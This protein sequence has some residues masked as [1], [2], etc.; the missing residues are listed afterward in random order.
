[1]KV[2]KQEAWDKLPFPDWRA[3]FFLE[4]FSESLSVE[5]P[6]FHQA[7]MMG[8][9]DLA[10]EVLENIKVYEENDKG[11]G[12]LTSSLKELK[13][14][15]ERDVV[16]KS[17]F[18]DILDVFDDCAKN[19]SADK[20]SRSLIIQLS[21][22]CKRIIEQ[23]DLYFDTIK[24]LLIESICDNRDISEKGRI[25]EEIYS[26]TRAY[27]TFLLSSGYSPTYL[28]NKTQVLTRVSNY[29]NRIYKDQ[30]DFFFNSLD[31]KVRPFKVF[32]GIKTNKKETI[33]KYTPVKGVKILDSIPDKHYTISTKTFSKFSPDFYFQI[34]IE[35]LDYV[36]ASLLAN[37]KIESEIDLLKTLL[38][39]TN[40]SIH[41]NCYVDYKAKGHTYQRDVNVKLL[42]SLLTYDLR[43]S[44]FNQYVNYDFRS[45]FEISSQKKIEGVLKNLRQVKESARL[46]QKLLSL[47]IGLES[48]S[49]SGDEK[50]I[51]ASVINFLP[52]LYAIQSI[53]QRVEYVLILLESYHVSIPDTVKK[54]HNI[55]DDIFSRKIS[56]D[57]F[58]K[59]VTCESSAKE[60]CASI[61]SLDFLYFRFFALYNIVSNKKEIRKRISYTREDI[62]KQLY[63][64]YQKRNNIVHV[65]FSD[66][67]S[68]YAINHLSD[69]VNTLLLIV[70]D[71]VK[72]AN[73][74]SNLT[75]DDVILSNQLVVDN[76]IKSIDKNPFDK[77]GDLEFSVII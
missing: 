18:G 23:H 39:K 47:W 26:L 13:L 76:K 49:Y 4:C 28:F 24:A 30:V 66:S 15:L 42:N 64:I 36:G 22:L 75:L 3:R 70:L 60:V 69:Y 17:I 16:S 59:I 68:H 52:K 6:H 9:L 77:I 8:V 54:R 72:G 41:D 53:R 50:S 5:T 32:F 12:Y 1:M 51:I 44:Q 74:L 20:F 2:L 71:T 55:N 33:K 45:R 46:E 58:Y 25:T 62:E 73:Y 19:F 40:L 65:G 48:L 56:L 29:N 35:T 27:V 67:L 21:I 57:D 34:S 37:E 11:K 14:A 38:S 61:I 10:K 63:R 7:K 43:N 31:C